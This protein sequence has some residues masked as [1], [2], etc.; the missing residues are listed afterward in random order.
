MDEIASPAES[1]SS[2]ASSAAGG[3]AKGPVHA[4]HA[5]VLSERQPKVTDLLPVRPVWVFVALL[6]ALAG[7]VAIEA[8]HV[9]AAPLQVG[10]GASH[11]AALNATQRGS[12]AAW[13]SSALLALAAVLAIVTFG[14][15]AHRVD[16]Y[17]GQYRVWLWTAAAL[18]WLSVDAATGIH[19][20]LGLGL[21]FLAGQQVFTGSLAAGCT[22]TWIVV[23]G[24]A[25]G[26]LA[27]RLA[28]EIR[29]SLWSAASLL[30]A[31]GLYVYAALLQLELLAA[32]VVL[33]PGVVQTATILLANLALL[34][35]VGFFARHVYLDATGRL[36]VHIDP[37]ARSKSKR[38][39]LRVV[40]SEKASET[41]KT[42]QAALPAKSAAK[43]AEPARFGASPAAGAAKPGASISKS[44]VASPDEGEEDEDD[45]EYGS[46]VS[47]SERRRLKKLARR[48][49]RR[50]A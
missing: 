45:D 41:S 44:I 16:D 47:K 4:Y 13:Y 27:L 38:A 36:K 35:T 37:A 50:A 6:L 33:A 34:S 7:V 5:A 42:A 26:T 17:R 39:K 49:Q 14:I 10:E 29:S 11:L 18:A 9:Q 43:P 23:Y 24:L 12:L 20:A 8:I 30:A 21:T 48:E 40:K 28:F 2:E 32:P 22:L 15:R 1:D 46:G 31:G 19:D 25:L 3:S